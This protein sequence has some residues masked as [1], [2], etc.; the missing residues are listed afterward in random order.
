MKKIVIKLVVCIVILTIAA[1]LVLGA[2]QKVDLV[3]CTPTYP[4][5]GGFVIFNNSSG[6]DHNLELTV[7]LKGVG[8]VIDYDIYLFVDGSWYGGAPVGTV[9]TNKGDNA[10]FHINVSLIPGSHILALDVTL[11]GSTA[12][13]YETPGIHLKE[14]TVLVFE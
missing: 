12:D 6:T 2:A 5:G 9:T 1:V 11:K 10:N 4:G 7:S 14:G 3:P 13:E 8:S